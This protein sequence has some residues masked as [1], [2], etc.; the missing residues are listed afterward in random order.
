MDKEAVIN[1]A[2]DLTENSPVNYISPEAAISSE[3]AGMKLFDAPVFAFGCAVDELYTKFKQTDVIGERHISPREWL[4]DASTVIS[5][6]LPYTERIRVANAQSRDWPA[7]E[8]LH[9]RYEGQLFVKELSVQIHKALTDAGYQSL[10]PILDPRNKSWNDGG[11]YSASW[12]ERHVAFACGLGTFGLTK[13]I[14]TEKGACGRLGS[15]I[16]ALDLSKDVRQ[17]K[18]VYEYCTMCGLCVPQCPAGAISLTAGK[19]NTLCGALLDKT[20]AKHKPRYG[21]G[22]CQVNVPCE[23]GIPGR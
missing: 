5:F 11:K 16:T 6:F 21:C 8:W 15:V 18:D 20:T 3:Y 9:G 12:S 10:V 2:A 4:P 14:I 7:E 13:G 23:S 22:K 19:E 17:Y 1:L